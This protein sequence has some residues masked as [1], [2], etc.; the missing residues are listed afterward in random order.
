MGGQEKIL[1]W[2][3]CYFNENELAPDWKDKVLSVMAI[4]VP[5]RAPVPNSRY[6]NPAN[7]VFSLGLA[8]NA[9]PFEKS[10]LRA[11]DLHFVN[12]K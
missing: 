7:H 11:D 12:W 3:L 1:S 9:P 5:L 2:P 4:H 8:H 6:S 10:N